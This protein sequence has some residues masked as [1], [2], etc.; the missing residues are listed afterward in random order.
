MSASSYTGAGAPLRIDAV[1]K[2]WDR[3]RSSGERDLGDET[4]SFTSSELAFSRMVLPVL[5][6]L[7]EAKKSREE[8]AMRAQALRVA[9]DLLP[10]AA[11]VLSEAGRFLTSN[12]SAQKLF[13][14]AAVSAAVIESAL[15]AVESGTERR[16]TTVLRADGSSLRVVPA[17]LDP[18]PAAGDPLVVFLIPDN[19]RLEVATGLLVSRHGLSPMQAKVVAFVAQGLTNKEVA[20]ELGISPETVHKHLNAVFQRTGLGTRGAV[21]ALAFGA[22]FGMIPAE[23]A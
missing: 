6:D 3:L 19:A 22:P 9:L 17:Q 14:G 12:G 13:G 11:I 1:R 7:A 10:V 18:R 5:T 23:T 2:L 4:E 8:L 21:V 20:A 15:K 16:V